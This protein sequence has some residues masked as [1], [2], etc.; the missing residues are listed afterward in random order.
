MTERLRAVW[1][2]RM[3]FEPALALQLAL[4]EAV[5]DGRALPT[6]L[7]VEHPAVLTLGRRGQRSDVLW[8]DAQLAAMGVE[9]C[10][11][12]RGG[13]VTLHAPGQLVAYPIVPIGVEVRRHVTRLGL[14]AIDLLEGQGLGELALRTDPLGVWYRP[15]GPERAK[16]ASIGVH[17]RRG[18][19]V[20]GIA[21]NL[22]VDARLFTALVSCGMP[23]VSMVSATRLGAAPLP[24][25]QAA[26]RYAE[27]FA[28]RSEAMLERGDRDALVAEVV[29]GGAAALGLC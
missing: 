6:V 1:L 17:I 25:E 21:V 28:G 18:V 29:P 13:Q 2:G 10:E 26:W 15:D 3:R 19:T 8:T 12:P 11:T 16:V 23:G 27:A 4:R 14:A 20:Q 24:V 22:D 9:V 5:A 7:L